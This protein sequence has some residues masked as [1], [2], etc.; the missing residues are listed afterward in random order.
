[1]ANIMLPRYVVHEDN[2]LGELE[3]KYLRCCCGCLLKTTVPRPSG[4][5]NPLYLLMAL[6]FCK[7]LAPQRLYNP[8]LLLVLA[9]VLIHSAL[10]VGMAKELTPRTDL[11]DHTESG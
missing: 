6:L 7:S 1:M 5:E 9:V 10:P 4:S 8:W 2:F 3:Q 11:S